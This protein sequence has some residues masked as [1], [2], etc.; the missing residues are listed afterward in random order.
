MRTLLFGLYVPFFS[1]IKIFSV[2]YGQWVLQ[3]SSLTKIY[4]KLFILMLNFHEELKTRYILLRGNKLHILMMK[5]LYL[6]SSAVQFDVITQF[7]LG[8]VM[9]HTS[10][11]AA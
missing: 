10:K 3:C 9:R 4:I 2:K 1:W 5:S 11:H 7:S 6:Q 8:I